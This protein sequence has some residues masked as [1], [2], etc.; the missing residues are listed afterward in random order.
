MSIRMIVRLFVV[1]GMM[2]VAGTSP[3]GQSGYDLLQKALVAERAAGNL[4]QAI[5]LYDR[6]VREFPQDRTL[7]AR[8]LV[9]MAECYQKLGDSRARAIYE[10][11][12]R[13]YGDQAEAAT[14][15]RDR[16]REQEPKQA[17]VPGDRLV[18]GPGREVD[19][20][21]TVSPDGR[22]LTY[23][24]WLGAANVVVRDL[25]T[26][27]DR[28]IT[29]NTRDVRHG[30]ASWSVISRGGDQVAY[31]WQPAVG[32]GYELRVVPFDGTS[33]A[34]RLLLRRNE[35]GGLRPFDWSP[36]GRWIALLIEREDQSSQIALVDTR[37]G[38]LRVLKSIDWRGVGKAVFSPDG[39]YLAYD[40]L[41]G[42]GIRTQRILVMAVDASRETE[43]T[44]ASASNAVMGWRAD[45]HL[46]FAS[47]RS[48]SIGLWAVRVDEGRP[49]AAPFLVKADLSS[50][51]SLGLTRGGALYVWK[52]AGAEYVTTAAIDLAA[53]ELR[54]GPAEPFQAFVVSRGRPAWSADGSRLLYV[55]CGPTG[56]SSCRIMLRDVESGATREVP[57]SLGYVGFPRLGP[58]GRTI[59]AEGT[60]LKGRRA[61]YLIDAST[62]STTFVADQIPYRRRWPDW[63]PD[64]RSIY[65]NSQAPNEPLVLLRREIGSESETEVFRT[66]AC[67]V[68]L[69]RVSPDARAVACTASDPATRSVTLLVVRREG[70]PAEPVMRVPSSETLFPWQWTPNGRAILVRKYAEGRSDEL[71]LAPVG[72]EPRPRRLNI[73]VRNWSGPF[74]LSPD[75]RR[76]AFVASAGADGAEVWALENFLSPAGSGQ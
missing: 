4:Q 23:V 8:A 31:S 52:R 76:I 44:A 47:D 75:G 40:L 66:S 37:T 41:E 3:A 2:A 36:D 43:I 54:P 17:T 25:V 53:G 1:A 26:G 11:V 61:I 15:A 20:F 49:R 70:G 27:T 32:D 5:E 74:D 24:D 63:W 50:T 9:R 71:W 22:F 12:V 46:L 69:A 30:D 21:G 16:L 62:G 58:D 73:D 14:A 67:T 64:G 48:G 39:R 57:H 68:G 38:E 10:R 7:A 51:W 60:D 19:L 65:Y 28:A 6:V 34:S 45:G 18:W 55:S 33:A 42:E 29:N 35:R 59:L 13:E 72:G 56:G